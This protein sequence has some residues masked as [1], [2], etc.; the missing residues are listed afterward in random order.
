MLH[1]RTPY[2]RFVDISSLYVRYKIYG[3]NICLAAED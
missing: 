3:R 2:S 1:T